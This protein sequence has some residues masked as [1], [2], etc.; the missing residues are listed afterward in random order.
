MLSQEMAEKKEKLTKHN[1]GL[2]LAGH[3]CL[4]EQR[5]KGYPIEPLYL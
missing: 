4:K 3:A 2:G 5:A 1:P